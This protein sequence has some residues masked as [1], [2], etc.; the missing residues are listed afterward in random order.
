MAGAC[1]KADLMT[2]P[3]SRLVAG[4]GESTKATAEKPTHLADMVSAILGG[5]RLWLLSILTACGTAQTPGT[6]DTADMPDC[7]STDSSTWFIDDDG[8]GFGD[9]PI[10]ALCQPDGAVAIDGDCDDSN[11]F[12][13][14]GAEDICDGQDNDCNGEIDDGEAGTLQTWYGDL[15]DDGYGFPGATTEGCSQPNGY[16]DNDLDCDDSNSGVYPGAPEICDGAANDCDGDRDGWV[17]DDGMATFISADKETVIDVSDQLSLSTDSPTTYTLSEP[18]VLTLCDGTWHTRLILDADDLTVVG[19]NGPE[20]V[21][22][23]ASGL[24]PVVTISAGHSAAVEGLALRNGAADQGGGVYVAPLACPEE[25]EKEKDAGAKAVSQPY[26]VLD[27]LHITDSTAT[28]GGG[29]YASGCVYL[30]IDDTL[31]EANSAEQGGG[32]YIGMSD[33]PNVTF[34]LD[35][36]TITDN[37]AQDGGGLWI[38]A[39]WATINDTH[40]TDNTAEQSGGGLVLSG[41]LYITSS[42]KGDTA[43]TGNI[44][45]QGGGVYFETDSWL[46]TSGTDW[47]GAKD[48]ATGKTAADNVT[49]D[50]DGPT[51]TGAPYSLGVMETVTCA[52]KTGCEREEEKSQESQ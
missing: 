3:P 41:S 27:A 26:I 8:D 32:V 14:P 30:E 17:S 24:G 28:Q 22:L 50:I 38:G 21:A 13:W 52:D 42:D 18:G 31:I 11:E 2:S 1:N 45:E 7:E 44:A 51:L 33:E 15:D 40:V 19:I 36:T 12:T 29:V 6:A 23:D 20:S 47:G 35:D 10:T 37:T 43:V 34:Y 9:E 48:E 25:K 16:V 49:D 5:M 46:Y 39:S 4:Q